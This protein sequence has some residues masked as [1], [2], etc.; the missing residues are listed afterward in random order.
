MTAPTTAKNRPPFPLALV[1]MLVPALV[2]FLGACSED[3]AGPEAGADVEDVRDEPGIVED[4]A[5]D[6][7]AFFEDPEPFLGET[8]TV[9]AEVAD[10]VSPQAF[11]IAGEGGREP[12]LVVA[13]P[14]AIPSIS[15]DSVVKVTG[16][17]RDFALAD[18][19]RE[20]GVDLDDGLF[21]EYDD[22]HVIVAKTVTVVDPNEDGADG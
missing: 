10:I 17:V 2:L 1:L 13:A 7:E 14:N 12:I 9:S 4:D 15:D 20:V 11:E 6:E 8:V 5:F 21:T 16:T 18:I 3:S 22:D 19:E